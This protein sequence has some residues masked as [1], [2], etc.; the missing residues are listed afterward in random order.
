MSP[1]ARQELRDWAERVRQRKAKEKEPKQPWC[2]TD[3]TDAFVFVVCM[4]GA[5]YLLA[6]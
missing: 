2:F 6:R 4:V 3:Y 5:T 1:T